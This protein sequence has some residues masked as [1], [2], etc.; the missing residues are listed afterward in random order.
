MADKKSFSEFQNKSDSL[1][2]GE[3]RQAVLSA[4]GLSILLGGTFLVAPNFPIVFASIAGLIQ[5]LTKKKIPQS[6]IKRV[7]KNLEKK[8]II[9]A[10]GPNLK[11]QSVCQNS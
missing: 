7:L 6:K 1:K 3:L 2:H 8:E 4:I 5:E 9:P 11:P 10:P